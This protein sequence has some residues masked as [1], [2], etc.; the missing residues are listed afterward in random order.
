M[1]FSTLL[2]LISLIPA[3]AETRLTPAETTRLALTRNP[4]LQAARGIVAEAEARAA[5]AGRLANPELGLEAAG[6]QD[7]EGRVEV[8]LTQWF[9]VTSRLRW[10]RKLSS[11]QIAMARLEVAE[12]E[13]QLVTAAQLARVE[14]AAAREA[15]SLAATQIQ[16][17]GAE[18]ESLKKQAAEGLASGLD[19]GSSALAASEIG[20]LQSSLAVEE[21]SA[22]AKMA[23]L[24]GMNAGQ[25]PATDSLQLPASLPAKTATLSRPDLQLAE[26]ALEAGD[27][28]VLL[29]R[30]S[31]WQDVGVG[32]FAEG[33]R[34]RDEPE[35]IEPE[36]LLG[37]RVSI[38]FPFWQN[39]SAKVAEKQAGRARLENQLAALQLAAR[40]EATAAWQVMKIRH[41]A[42]QQASSEVLPAAR[43]LLADT[44][45]AHQR[46]ESELSQV[47]RARD[48]LMALERADLEARKAFHLARIHWLSATGALL[49]QP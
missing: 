28:D 23:T 24:L 38:P 17:A 42:A 3:S 6:G 30:S 25:L 15:R 13:L 2:L 8:A 49:S 26:L 19:A 29:A 14:L 10:E 18:G 27:A 7:F 12:K 46:G 31:R 35:G 21:T 43:R 34:T 37:M 4:E 45:A 1:R 32:I 47:F 33:E 11:L 9:P 39:G 5:G 16:T 36:G 22:S 48:R 41:Q 44:T 40:N 20:L